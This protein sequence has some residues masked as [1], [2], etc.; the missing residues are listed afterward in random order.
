LIHPDAQG[1]PTRP[2]AFRTM[3]RG[4][5]GAYQLFFFSQFF[6]FLLLFSETMT[7]GFCCFRRTVRP[8][9]LA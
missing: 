7:G 5:R 3:N 1:Q 2:C 4:V 8:W 9:F 6:F